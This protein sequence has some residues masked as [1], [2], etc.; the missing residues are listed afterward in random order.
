I[1]AYGY[2]DLDSWLL[3]NNTGNIVSENSSV[4]LKATVGVNNGTAIHNEGN[5]TAKE[6]IL[7]TSYKG[8]VINYGKMISKNSSVS[9]T[10]AKVYETKN[11]NKF[12]I[13]NN[14][15]NTGSITAAQEVLLRTVNGS[16]ENQN[17][18]TSLK[19]TVTIEA[20]QHADYDK[21]VAVGD[22][23]NGTNAN[24]ESPSKDDRADITAAQGIVLEAAGNIK[25]IGDYLV[26]DN[27]DITVQAQGNIA[28]IGDYTLAKD[29]N[30]SVKAQVDVGNTGKY[31]VTKSGNI[32]VNAG[33]NVGNVGS[34]SIGQGGNITVHADDSVGNAGSYNIGT[35]GEIKVSAKGDVGNDSSYS[36]GNDG[37]IVVEAGHDVSNQGSY[38]VA[39]NGSIMVTAKNLVTNGSISSNNGNYA[40]NGTGDIVVTATGT[41]N[42]EGV[43]TGGDIMNYGNYH[44]NN[45]NITM[46]SH[47]D[48]LNYGVMETVTG[49]ISIVSQNGVIFNKGGA[50]LLSGN[51]NVTLKAASTDGYYYYFDNYG[52]LHELNDTSAL[53]LNQ[54]GEYVARIDGVEHTVLKNG[55]VFNAG[56]IM[57]LGGTITLEAVQG[58]LTN[59]DDFNTLSVANS[60]DTTSSYKGKAIATGNIDFKAVNGHL[61]NE[62]DLESGENVSLTAA[63]GLTNF[64]YNVYA[65]KN[66]TLTATKGDVVNT[67]VLESVYGDVTLKAE[68]G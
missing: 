39:N 11:N 57:A 4:M 23:N 36:I 16:I 19:S 41:A 28:N 44:T 64:A 22:I 21:H 50:D 35:D 68:H 25:N 40:I 29:G 62:K 5:V 55:S 31:T 12:D 65:G 18:I 3:L 30:I 58:N 46:T 60:S 33:R 63:E 1:K 9:L 66:I 7:L 48:V 6:E 51:G 20:G 67:A 47:E 17:K 32:S 49:D 45:G 43:T 15:T 24:P 27:G 38:T 13:V 54:Y 37:S 56:D 8:D 34:Y 61:Y 26:T 59:Y 42:A 53:T 52:V 10:A 2:V 14:I